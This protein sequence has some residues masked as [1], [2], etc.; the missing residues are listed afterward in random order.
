MGGEMLD[1]FY[2][3]VR[4]VGRLFL[5]S[6][7]GGT[8]KTQKRDKQLSRKDRKSAG[9]VETANQRQE[10]IMG[11]TVIGILMVLALAGVWATMNS[12]SPGSAGEGAGAGGGGSRPKRR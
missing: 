5:G 10:M 9:N 12:P 7:I 2:D 11:F 8:G 4:L 1:G 3:V 6:E